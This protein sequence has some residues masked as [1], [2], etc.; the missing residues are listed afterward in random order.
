MLKNSCNSH[1]L[2]VKSCVFV[3]PLKMVI[4]TRDTPPWLR[5]WDDPSLEDPSDDQIKQFIIDEPIDIDTLRTN[6]KAVLKPVEPKSSP[7]VEAF[8]AA[9]ATGSLATV[10]QALKTYWEDL[11]SDSRPHKSDLLY[12]GLEEI[13]KQDNRA[14]FDFFAGGTISLSPFLQSMVVTCKFY[15]IMELWLE[16]GWDIN[17]KLSYA[18]PPALS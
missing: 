9:C 2:Q 3:H 8:R 14:V 12:P 17:A 10:Q 7:E 16:K 11:A 6:R 18:S 15:S 13:I 1:A 4:D 5:P